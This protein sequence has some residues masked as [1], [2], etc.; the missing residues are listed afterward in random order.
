MSLS[1]GPKQA[2]ALKYALDKENSAPVVVAS[3]LGHIAQK[4]VDVA[5]ENNVPVFEDDSLAALLSQLQ[6]G[7]EIPAE[8]YQAIVDIYVYFLNFTL[9]P[10]KLISSSHSED[11]KTA[12]VSPP[13]QPSQPQPIVQTYSPTGRIVTPPVDDEDFMPL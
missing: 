10:D 8:L 4:I 2:A 6:A 7:Q 12:S 11:T 9:S 13:P 1:N 5:T 3:G